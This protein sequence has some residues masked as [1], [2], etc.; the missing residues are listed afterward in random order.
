M[1]AL[2]AASFFDALTIEISLKGTFL[3]MPWQHTALIK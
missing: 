1:C 2:N 3:V